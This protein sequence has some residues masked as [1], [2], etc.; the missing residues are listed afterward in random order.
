MLEL[1]PR[2]KNT[3]RDMI[4]SGYNLQEMKLLCQ[5]LGVNWENVGGAN[6]TRIMFAQELVD[7]FERRGRL[8]DLVEQVQVDRPNLFNRYEYEESRPYDENEFEQS[9]TAS[10]NSNTFTWILLI[11]LILIAIYAI[12]SWNSDRKLREPSVF[13]SSYIHDLT[14]LDTHKAWE[15]LSGDYKISKYPSGFSQFNDYYFPF[16]YVEILKLEVTEETDTTAS[17][18]VFL[19]FTKRDDGSVFNQD[20]LYI[21]SRPTKDDTWLITDSSP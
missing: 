13:V 20:I 6:T 8:D 21:L 2:Q 19:A 3:L 5:N 16:R 12:Y 14:G 15:K 1:D 7:Y 4:A 17:V 18:R 10:N 9:S 11:A